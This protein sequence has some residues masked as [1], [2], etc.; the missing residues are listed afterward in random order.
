MFVDLGGVF[1]LIQ[2]RDVEPTVFGG[3]MAGDTVQV[4]VT[5]CMTES[6]RVLLSLDQS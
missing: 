1:G 2:Y 3:L 6:H 4:T 5:A